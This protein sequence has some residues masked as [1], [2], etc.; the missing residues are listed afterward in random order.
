MKNIL[1]ELFNDRSQQGFRL[2]YSYLPIAN[3]VFDKRQQIAPLKPPRVKLFPIKKGETPEA[4]RL[5]AF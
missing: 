4:V 5:L 3:K 1:I 2:V